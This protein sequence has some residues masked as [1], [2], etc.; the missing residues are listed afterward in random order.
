MRLYT[1]ESFGI[2]PI[3]FLDYNARHPAASSE[4]CASIQHPSNE[5][6]PPVAMTLVVHDQSR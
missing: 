2:A 3:R 6:Y 1:I 5:G 4:C